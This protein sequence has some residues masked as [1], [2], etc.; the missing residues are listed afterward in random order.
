[1]ASR[2][3]R[4]FCYVGSSWMVNLVS[5]GMGVDV[6]DGEASSFDIVG[7]CSVDMDDLWELC[8]WLLR[9]SGLWL[10]WLYLV[11]RTGF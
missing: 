3:S 11:S 1:M 4:K 7:S 10:G 5:A 6:V 9:F 8:M 2:F